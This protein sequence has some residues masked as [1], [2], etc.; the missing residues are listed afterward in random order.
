RLKDWENVLGDVGKQ[1]VGGV[2]VV[3]SAVDKHCIFTGHT[4]ATVKSA[5]Y[6]YTV[7]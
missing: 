6:R 7:K 1:F 3:R 5:P 2:N 4:Y